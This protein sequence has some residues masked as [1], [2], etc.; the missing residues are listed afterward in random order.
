MY[1]A[2]RF[3]TLGVVAQDEEREELSVKGTFRCRWRPDATDR[4]NPAPP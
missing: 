4:V 2:G 1:V 3:Q